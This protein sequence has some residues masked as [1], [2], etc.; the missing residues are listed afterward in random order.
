[1]KNHLSGSLLPSIAVLLVLLS[2]VVSPAAAQADLRPL[3]TALK[4]LASFKADID[5]A[6]YWKFREAVIALRSDAAGRSEAEA[7]LLDFLK[8]AAPLPAKMAVCRELRLVGSAA[9][10]PAL[11]NLLADKNLSDPARYALEDIAGPAPDQ[12]LLRALGK[13]SGD[14]RLGIISSLGFRKTAEAVGPLA[15]SLGANDEREAVASASAL[16]RIGG[17]DAAGALVQAF[18]SPKPAVKEAAMTAALA[19]AET[20]LP[21]QIAVQSRIINAVLAEKPSAAILRAATILTIAASGNNARAALLDILKHGDEVAREAAIAKIKDVLPAGEIGQVTPLLPDLS[22]GCRIKLIAVLSGYPGELVRP[23][24]LPSLKS[25][26]V[27]ERI[28]ALKALESAGDASVVPVLAQAAAGSTGPEQ[29][30]ARAA[31]GLVQ[32]READAAILALMDSEAPDA[33]KSEAILAAGERRIFTAKSALMKILSNPSIPMRIQA[34]KVLKL[35]GTPSDVPGLLNRLVTAGDEAEIEETENTVA[36]L[37]GKI[38]EPI[39]RAAPVKTRLRSETDP[40][41]KA[42][43]IRILGKIGDDSSLADLRRELAV[44]ETPVREAAIRAL[45]EWP[46]AAPIEDVYDLAKSS[47][48]E[49]HRLLALRGFIRMTALGR[50]RIPEYAVSDLRLAVEM[51]RRPEEKRM[52]LAA[53][54]EFACPAALALARA[55]L[56]TPDLAAEAGA[57]VTAIEKKLKAK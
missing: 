57:A 9:S 7:K 22:P 48:N 3:E 35:I 17:T 24:I 38:A 20:M 36:V 43:L 45:I 41:R 46:S 25:D 6:A 52:V 29:I 28:A 40:N 47:L 42:A 54:P 2:G 26:L 21:A 4:N 16:G 30:A 11:E 12:A 13:T 18:K 50:F 34:L 14:L 39:G 1:M 55:M 37:A 23:A 32:G 15:K 8:S 56:N 53:L 33:V 49:N 31:L 10:V 19:C 44:P 27:F 5:S 51:A